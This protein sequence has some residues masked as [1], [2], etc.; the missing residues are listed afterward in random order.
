MLKILSLL[1]FVSCSHKWLSEMEPPHHAKNFNVS[2][3]KNLDPEYET[4]NLPIGFST[5]VIH[6]GLVYQPAQDGTLNVYDLNSGRPVWTVKEE[7][8]LGAQVGILGDYVY[9]GSYGGRLY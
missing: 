8:S 2:W 3:S 6:S 7:Q 4:G 5:P 1:F 9:Y